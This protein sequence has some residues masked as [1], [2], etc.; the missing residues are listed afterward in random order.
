MKDAA[1]FP[2]TQKR[3]VLFVDII[4]KNEAHRQFC[5]LCL[6]SGAPPCH[7]WTQIICLYG[8]DI[9]SGSDESFNELYLYLEAMEADLQAIVCRLMSLPFLSRLIQANRWTNK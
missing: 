6:L 9:V 7:G 4:G 2:R 1:S 5:F 3:N 8:M